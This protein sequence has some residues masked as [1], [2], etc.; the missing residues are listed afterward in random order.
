MYSVERY[1]KVRCAA[2]VN[3]CSEQEAARVF[4]IHCKKRRLVRLAHTVSHRRIAPPIGSFST[5]LTEF[6]QVNRGEKS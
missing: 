2:L 1:V 6:H 3:Q 5:R 4:G